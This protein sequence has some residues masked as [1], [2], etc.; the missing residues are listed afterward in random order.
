M[1]IRSQNE[2]EKPFTELPYEVIFKTA[3]I[4]KEKPPFCPCIVY[5]LNLLQL[6]KHEFQVWSQFVTQGIVKNI[7]QKNLGIEVTQI[8]TL[9]LSLQDS[10]FKAAF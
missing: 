2:L 7:F 6:S 8:I 3:A 1:K 10:C 5:S 4:L 9:I